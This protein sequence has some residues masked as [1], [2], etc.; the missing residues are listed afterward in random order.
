MSEVVSRIGIGARRD[1]ILLCAERCR[2]EVR[3]VKG[4]S[5]VGCPGIVDWTPPGNWIISP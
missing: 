3:W 1:G 2:G 4:R 5:M